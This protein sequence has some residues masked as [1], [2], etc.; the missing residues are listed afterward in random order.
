MENGLLKYLFSVHIILFCTVFPGVN[1]RKNIPVTNAE[2]LA[3]NKG[4]ICAEYFKKK[5][6]KKGN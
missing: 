5:K 3:P 4:K 1:L 2:E 6:K